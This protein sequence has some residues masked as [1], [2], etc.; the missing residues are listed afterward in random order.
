MSL[1]TRYVDAEAIKDEESMAKIRK[2]IAE[3]PGD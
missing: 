3:R 2:L 1:Y